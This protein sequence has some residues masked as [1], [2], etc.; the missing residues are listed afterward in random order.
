MSGLHASVR[1]QLQQR[2]AQAVGQRWRAI[3]VDPQHLL[4]LLRVYKVPDPTAQDAEIG[5]LEGQLQEAEALYR[6]AQR[7]VQM[8]QDAGYARAVRDLQPELARVRQEG[9]MSDDVD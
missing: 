4:D 7:E 1:R 5:R 3:G 6:Q 9:G 8:A 2:A